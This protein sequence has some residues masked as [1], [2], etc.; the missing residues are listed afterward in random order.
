MS[1]DGPKTAS[2]EEK[3]LRLIRNKGPA[4]VGATAALPRVPGQSG[5]APSASGKRQVRGLG[6]P[7]WWIAAFNVGLGSLIVGEL[8]AL[9]FLQT[10]PPPSLPVAVSVKPPSETVKTASA[11]EPVMEESFASTASLALSASRPMFQTEHLNDRT[12]T[13][14]GSTKP[15]E[16]SEKLQALQGRLS[17]I[18]IIA[19]EPNQAIIED[20]QSKRTYFVAKGQPVIEGLVVDNVFET[21]AVLLSANGEKIELSL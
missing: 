13:S 8:G 17:L 4:P 6:W 21:R 16:P 19:G 1:P 18:G 20:A 14:S 9:F 7:R 12:V 5:Q 2:P 3:L 10:E 15:A 11:P